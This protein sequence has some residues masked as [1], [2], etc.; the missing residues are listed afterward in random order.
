MMC[1]VFSSSTVTYLPRATTLTYV[2][3][4]TPIGLAKNNQSV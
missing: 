4:S 3:F 1:L 2:S